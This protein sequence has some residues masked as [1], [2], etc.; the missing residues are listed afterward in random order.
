MEPYWKVHTF[1][2]WAGYISSRDLTQILL[3][4]TLLYDLV[5]DYAV[6]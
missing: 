6:L 5:I 2:I 1:L 3:D 4:L